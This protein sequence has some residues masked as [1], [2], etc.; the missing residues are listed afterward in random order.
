[1]EMRKRQAA[2]VKSRRE[3]KRAAEEERAE[4][5]A[6]K[7][8][9]DEAVPSEH[10]ELWRRFE[11]CQEAMRSVETALRVTDGVCAHQLHPRIGVESL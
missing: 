8:P 4:K 11:G 2:P 10:V 1:M 9:R 6:A 7:Q 3:K 5:L